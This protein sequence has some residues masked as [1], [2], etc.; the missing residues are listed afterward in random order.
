MA[1]KSKSFEAAVRI[2]QASTEAMLDEMSDRLSRDLWGGGRKSPPTPEELAQ[3]ERERIEREVRDREEWKRTECVFVVQES[4]DCC[5]P[6]EA[7]SWWGSEAEAQAECE[8]LEGDQ[9][10][11]DYDWFAIPK[12]PRD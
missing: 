3:W 8:R 11:R 5:S 10:G 7:L 12:G 6:G 2:M 9:R 1:I 4:G